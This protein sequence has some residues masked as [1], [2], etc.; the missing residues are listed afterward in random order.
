LLGTFLLGLLDLATGFSSVFVLTRLLLPGLFLAGFFGFLIL[1]VFFV[2]FILFILF[3]LFLLGLLFVLIGFLITGL[4][5]TR[6]R[7]RGGSYGSR[8]SLVLLSLGGTLALLGSAYDKEDDE[9]NEKDTS[10]GNTDGN[11][12]NGTSGQTSDS[13]LRS[14]SRSSTSRSSNNGR[15]NGGGDSNLFRG[16]WCDRC[17]GSDGSRGRYLDCAQNTSNGSSQISETSG[18]EVRGGTDTGLGTLSE[19]NLN[20]VSV[21]SVNGTLGLRGRDE[22][23]S[24]GNARSV[25]ANQGGEVGTEFVDLSGGGDSVGSDWDVDL[26]GL[27]ATSGLNACVDGNGNINS[28]GQWLSLGVRH[29]EGQRGSASVESSGLAT[30]GRNRGEAISST[31][32]QGNGSGVAVVVTKISLSVASSGDIIFPTVQDG[33]NRATGDWGSGIRG[34]SGRS[35]R[36]RRVHGSVEALPAVGSFRFGAR[37]AQ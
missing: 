32:W 36:L 17:S 5:T 27:R 14:I 6:R 28:P 20:N 18:L 30:C 24:D 10:N 16:S 26:D 34:V 9:K 22:D 33:D 13:L 31:N 7:S 2:L 4:N 21:D 37:S 29:R 35:N 1:F 11:T 15:S 25:K 19:G 3:I 8:L 23:N 12:G